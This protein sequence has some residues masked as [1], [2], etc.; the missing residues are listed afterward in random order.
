MSTL[1]AVSGSPLLREYSQGAAQSAIQPIADFLA[2]GVDVPTMVGRYKKY[3]EKNRFRTP[4]T[5]RGLG[6]RATEL[7]FS[8]TDQTYNCEPHA[9]DIPLDNLEINEAQ[10][11][12]YAEN[13]LQ[14]A[15]DMAAEVGGLDHELQVVNSALTTLGAGTNKTWTSG[16]A[17]PIDDI[18]T[19]ILSVIKAAASGSAV[20][21]GILF[22]ATAW[23]IFKNHSLVRGRFIVGGN[24]QANSQLGV[25]VP[26]VD[27]VGQL[28]LGNADVRTSYMV[29]DTAA[30]GATASLSFV[31]DSKV[32]IFA[33]RPNP[34][35]RDPSFM[36][37]FRLRGNWMVPRT[38]PRDDGRVEVAGFDWSSD[39]KVTNSAAGV[40]LN[41]S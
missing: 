17:D 37:T 36:K 21:A 27:N 38:Y 35:R 2:P 32:I 41:I 23:K 6:G 24:R 26:T 14:E 22:G 39:V 20:V 4:N 19:Q 3:D 25:A 33:R 31:L 30:E 11:S 12:G 29:Y 5:R 40:L 34:T 7:A 9:L 1:A 18:D 15:A 8:A 13:L 28:F 16:S 10:E